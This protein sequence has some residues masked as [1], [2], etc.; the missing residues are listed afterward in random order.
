MFCNI[1]TAVA[2]PEVY[3]KALAMARNV[4][5]QRGRAI[6]HFTTAVFDLVELADDLSH[7][8]APKMT[9]GITSAPTR[10]SWFVPWPTAAGVST[11]AAS[12]GRRCRHCITGLCAA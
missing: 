3:L 4:A 2:G 7:E 11:F 5:H 10:R 9:R 8:A 6:R 1:G 12:I